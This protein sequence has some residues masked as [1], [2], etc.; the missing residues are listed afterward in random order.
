MLQ[1]EVNDRKKLSPWEG[2]LLPFLLSWQR[3]AS[4]VDAGRM[5]VFFLSRTHDDH[6][7]FFCLVLRAMRTYYCS[8]LLILPCDTEEGDCAPLSTVVVLSGAA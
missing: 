7:S 8:A 6:A 1:E 2:C 4:H 3:T 5:L